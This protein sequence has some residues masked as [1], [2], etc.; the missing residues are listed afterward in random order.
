VKTYSTK[1][2]ARKAGI[3][4]I[5]L[6]RWMV[7]GK[8]RPSEQIGMNGGKHWRWTERDIAKVREH[9]AKHFREGQ[10]RKKKKV[11]KTE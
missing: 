1:E 10:G 9:K 8:V 11:K 6:H 2:A 4:W 7:A 3:H 5:T